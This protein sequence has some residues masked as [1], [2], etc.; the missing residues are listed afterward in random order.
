[1]TG[2]AAQ[3]AIKGDVPAVE[4]VLVVAVIVVVI[5][6]LLVN[7]ILNRLIPASSRGV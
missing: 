2:L 1:M 7:L 3:S 6:N 5:F 4:A